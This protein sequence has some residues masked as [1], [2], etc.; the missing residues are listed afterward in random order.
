VTVYDTGDHSIGGFS[1][2]QGSDQSATFSSQFGQFRVSDLP[3]VS[4]HAPKSPPPAS[5]WG[6]QAWS[7]QSSPEASPQ[8]AP[9]EAPA[10]ASVWQATQG[11]DGGAGGD[12]LT[13]LERVAELH[14]KGVLSDAEFSAKKAELLSRI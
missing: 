12:P 1:Q 5:Q 13:Q 2:Q 3:V 7:P 6:S 10:Q 9:Q 4:G 11:S 8:W 14:R